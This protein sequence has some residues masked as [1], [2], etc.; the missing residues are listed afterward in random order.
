[1]VPNALVP[2]FCHNQKEAEMKGLIDTIAI[3]DKQSCLVLIPCEPQHSF[4]HACSWHPQNISHA[5]KLA[6]HH[7]RF[8]CSVQ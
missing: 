3:T 7:Y 8:H 6:S 4:R 2:H 5:V 1:M